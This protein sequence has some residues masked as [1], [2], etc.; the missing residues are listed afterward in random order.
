MLNWDEF[1][2]EENAAPSTGAA[3]NTAAEHFAESAPA[4]ITEIAE[5]AETVFSNSIF[6]STSLV[7]IIDTKSISFINM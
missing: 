2:A 4:P 6:E 7:F 3:N 5:I 1:N